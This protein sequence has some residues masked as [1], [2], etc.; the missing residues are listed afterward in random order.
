M[1][2]PV[3]VWLAVLGVIVVMLAIDL[4]A[5]RDAHVITA[6]EAAAW[7]GVWVAMGLGFGLLIWATSGAEFAGQYYAACGPCTSCWRT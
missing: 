5:H 2:V 1:D 7:S 6:K 3:T 4:F